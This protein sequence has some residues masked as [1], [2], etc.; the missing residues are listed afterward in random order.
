V[1]VVVA[2]AARVPPAEARARAV[3][4][5]EPKSGAARRRVAAAPRR[6]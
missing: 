1:V 6:S 4:V 2:A 3:Q 5:A